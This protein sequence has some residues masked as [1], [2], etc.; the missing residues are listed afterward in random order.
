MICLRP[1]GLIVLKAPKVG[2]I[3]FFCIFTIAYL[4]YNH[5]L[6]S[7]VKIYIIKLSV[8]LI[9]CNLIFCGM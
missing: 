8:L 5:I 1:Y 7:S 6:P 9:H 2:G 4:F 3:T